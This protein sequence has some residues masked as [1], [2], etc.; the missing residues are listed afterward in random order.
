MGQA[1]KTTLEVLV[2]VAVIV[3]MVLVVAA[4]TAGPVSVVVVVVVAVVVFSGMVTVA[5][6]AVLV[7]VQVVRVV[8]DSPSKEWR[9][10]EQAEEMMA[11][12]QP[13]RKPGI[14]ISFSCNVSRRITT[15]AGGGGVK[16]G[17]VVCVMV[18]V[19][20]GE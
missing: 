20:V 1:L 12:P 4:G 13:L 16:M 10:P 14:T 17:V 2:T 5:V 15:D 9:R 7:L 18:V 3:L 19:L 8:V 6:Y 11:L